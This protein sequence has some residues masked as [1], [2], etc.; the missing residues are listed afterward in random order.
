MEFLRI[1]AFLGLVLGTTACSGK[2][3]HY[4]GPEITQVVVNKGARQMHLLHHG[5]VLKSYDIGLGFAPEGDKKTRGD[6]R[7][8]EGDYTIDRRNPSLL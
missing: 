5:E 2:F 1:L 6:G 8:P 3:V 4:D 7:T